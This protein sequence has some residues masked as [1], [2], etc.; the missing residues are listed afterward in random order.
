MTRNNFS[1]RDFLKLSAAT[2]GGIA[3]AGCTT[4]LTTTAA[5]PQATT[6]PAQA[7]TAPVAAVATLADVTSQDYVW[8]CAVTSLA[9]WLDGRKGMTAAGQAL[10]VKTE[11]LGPQAYDAAAQL[12]VLEG[13]IAK[14]PAGIMIFPADTASLNDTMKSAL[15]ANIP[16]I[17][18]NSDVSDKTARYGFVGPDNRGAGQTGGLKAVELLNG[19]GNVAIMTVPGIEV[20][21]SRKQ[22]YLDIFAKY[23]DIKVVEVVDDKS[24]PATGLTVATALVQA[25]PDLNM[26][27]GTDATAGSAIARALKETGTAGKILVVAMDHDADMLP[28]V[29]DG[30]IS[31]TLAQNSVM[32]EWMAT[33]YLYWLTNNSIPAFKD[34]RVPNAP[35]CPKTTDVG[36][37]VVTKDNVQYWMSS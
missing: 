23:P 20:H 13:L 36:V 1:R 31:A 15:K 29:Q 26:I 6:A 32:E 11:F 9:F 33:Y 24:D 17:C 34:W 25:H 30:T 16:I 35:Q 3:L 2:A 22:G 21:E 37:T 8:L 7:T 27:I 18:V 5:P 14:K 19:K 12:T 10:G 28:Y 4:A